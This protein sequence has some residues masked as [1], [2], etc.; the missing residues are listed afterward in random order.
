RCI[1]LIQPIRAEQ[2]FQISL[3]FYSL[4]LGVFSKNINEILI[5][6]NIKPHI[7]RKLSKEGTPKKLCP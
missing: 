7:A 5:R 3:D 4:Y 1:R 6:N 2:P